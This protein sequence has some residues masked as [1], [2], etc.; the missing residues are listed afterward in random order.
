VKNKISWKEFTE[1]MR[2]DKDTG[3]FYRNKAVH[4]K[5]VFLQNF[6]GR[7]C[8]SVGS[9]GYVIISY[10]KKL[11]LAHRL[12]WFYEHGYFP[13][14]DIDHI[15]GVKD[16]NRIENLRVVSRSCNLRNS[17]ARVKNKSGITGVCWNK[18]AGVWVA[19]V[20]V[21]GT[22]YVG[23]SKELIDAAYLRYAAEQCLGYTKCNSSSSALGYIKAHV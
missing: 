2:Y 7:C 11:Y 19:S 13:E 10:R 14:T 9:F 22:K 8:G 21:M 4:K 20:S 5:M 18:T 12:A 15:N 3:K 16:D 1:Y 6:K 17:R 23:S